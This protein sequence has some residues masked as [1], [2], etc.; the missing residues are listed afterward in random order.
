MGGI[1]AAL[2][3]FRMGADGV[4]VLRHVAHR[5]KGGFFDLKIHYC[6][7]LSERKKGRG[8]DFVKAA[9]KSFFCSV[10][11]VCCDGASCSSA[12]LNRSA[13]SGTISVIC[14]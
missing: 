14:V 12:C 10:Y 13:Q 9:A 11:M 6:D 7:F 5:G 3:S 4:I 2:A 1:G 8:F